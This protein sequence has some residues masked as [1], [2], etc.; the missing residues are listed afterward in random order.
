MLGLY[1]DPQREWQF[2]CTASEEVK[3]VCPFIGLMV[4]PSLMSL[5]RAL[6]IA[7]EVCA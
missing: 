5:I 3:D 4:S 2:I 7:K 6:A 1:L